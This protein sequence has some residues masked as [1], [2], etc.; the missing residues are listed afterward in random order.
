MKCAGAGVSAPLQ[1]PV[2]GHTTL[3]WRLVV[4]G[5]VN[6]QHSVT[7]LGISSQTVTFKNHP[8]PTL[9]VER[10]YRIKQQ[11]EWRDWKWKVFDQICFCEVCEYF[12]SFYCSAAIPYNFS[13][14]EHSFSAGCS[15]K[16]F[17]MKMLWNRSNIDL[18][19]IRKHIWSMFY[20][21]DI[22]LHYIFHKKLGKKWAGLGL[23]CI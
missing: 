1:L 18:S 12:N 4:S 13:S 11:R 6:T 20:V 21:V 19:V 5:A 15:T 8:P 23:C 7:T 22:S 9:V 17:H 10:I 16:Y 14:H 3:D 2:R